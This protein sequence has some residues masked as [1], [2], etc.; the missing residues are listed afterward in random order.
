MCCPQFCSGVWLVLMVHV[1]TNPWSESTETFFQD[2][3]EVAEDKR[4]LRPPSLSIDALRPFNFGC[5]QPGYRVPCPKPKTPTALPKQ[6]VEGFK[7]VQ[8]QTVW[9]I[10]SNKIDDFKDPVSLVGS[11]IHQEM[12]WNFSNNGKDILQ[13]PKYW[14]WFQILWNTLC[15]FLDV[16]GTISYNHSHSKTLTSSKSKT[17]SGCQGSISKLKEDS[18]SIGNKDAP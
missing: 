9:S 18:G 5:L 17:A 15:M 10:S 14:T 3:L 13:L 8:R 1:K 6:T 7:D 4:D 12:S 2:R 16:P 11:G